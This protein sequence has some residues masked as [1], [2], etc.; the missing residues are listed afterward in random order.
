[1][2]KT[3]AHLCLQMLLL[4]GVLSLAAH[5]QSEFTGER[6]PYDAL[7]RLPTTDV[8]VDGSVLKV[9]FAPGELALPRT[10]ACELD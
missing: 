6:M 8:A 4:G 2:M 1:M 5:A 7:N 3:A 10:R 9:S